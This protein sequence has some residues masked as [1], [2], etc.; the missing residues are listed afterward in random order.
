[1]AEKGPTASQKYDVASFRLPTTKVHSTAGDS[2]SAD[3]LENLLKKHGYGNRLVT[4]SST[5]LPVLAEI[6]SHGRCELCRILSF[7][8]PVK[9]GMPPLVQTQLVSDDKEKRVVDLGQITSVWDT[10]DQEIESTWRQTVEE[11]LGK[12]PVQH[13]EKA[14]QRLYQNHA[15]RTQSSSGLTK[16]QISRLVENA[17]EDSRAHMGDVLRKAIKAGTGMVRLV[18]SDDAMDYLY[19]DY[20]RAATEKARRQAVGAYV[21]TQ[22]AALGGRFKRMPCIYV[23]AKYDATNVASITLING[24]WLAVDQSVRA[25]TEARKFAERTEAPS[26]KTEAQLLTAADER[27]AHRLECLAMGEIFSWESERAPAKN[28]I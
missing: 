25:G 12:F 5:E 10:N 27:I 13:T 16:K 17:A 6:Y 14:M 15:T 19:A 21:L 3:S 24:G 9:A 18:D 1:M 20:P 26:G 11:D 8:P 4:I 7:E 23:S 28:L 2:T 22:D